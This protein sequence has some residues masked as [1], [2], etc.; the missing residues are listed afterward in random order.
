MQNRG[1]DAEYRPPL[2]PRS[3]RP[4]LAAASYSGEQGFTSFPPPP[5]GP[6]T[7]SRGSSPIPPDGL[8]PD[9]PPPELPPRPAGLGNAAIYGYRPNRLESASSLSPPWNAGRPTLQ[10]FP[11]PPPSPNRPHSSQG[12]KPPP[13]PPRPTPKPVDISSIPPSN[14]PSTATSSP[15]L[16]SVQSSPNLTSFPPPPPGPPP[17]IPSPSPSQSP[18]PGAAQVRTGLS[19]KPS[20][21][22]SS[23]ISLPYSHVQHENG[24][25]VSLGSSAPDS[26]PP[27]Y[28]PS[29]AIEAR[30]SPVPTPPTVVASPAP[31]GETPVSNP[32]SPGELSF[33]PLPPLGT[34]PSPDE[35][36][37]EL[38][39]QMM[40]PAIELTDVDAGPSP[41]QGDDTVR[42]RP[43]SRQSFSGHHSEPESG[44]NPIAPLK[45]PKTP[46]NSRRPASVSFSSAG[47]PWGPPPT[48]AEPASQNG[49]EN[50]SAV[51]DTPSNQAKG[52]SSP[53]QSKSAPLTVAETSTTAHSAPYELYALDYYYPFPS[54]DHGVPPD[55]DGEPENP[56]ASSSVASRPVTTCIDAPVTF[57]TTWYSHFAA[58]E[59]FICSRCYADHIESS[60]FRDSFHVSA[61]AEGEPRV[62][63][64]SS[65]RMKDDLW[66]KAVS[67][68]YLQPVTDWMQ[69]RSRIPDCKGRAGV[70]GSDA[71]AMQWYSPKLHQFPSWFLVCQACYEDRIKVFPQ[72]SSYFEPFTQTQ[73]P[74]DAWSCDFYIP[75]VQKEYE[76]QGPRGDWSTF[77]REARA[78]M[79]MPGCPKQE[80]HFAYGRA[81]FRPVHGP[82]WLFVC[83]SCFSDR[84]AHTDDASKWAPDEQL[85]NMEGGQQVRCPMG[86]F[87]ISMA[88]S[89]AH[90]LQDFSVFWAAVNK[91]GQEKFCDPSGIIDGVWYTLHGVEPDS[92]YQVCSACYVSVAEPLGLSQFFRRKIN[93]PPGATLPCCMNPAHPRA[94]SFIPLL[95]ETYYTMSLAALAAYAD[96][97]AAIPPCPRDSDAR[98]DRGAALHTRL[99]GLMTL[100]N[101]P[102]GTKEDEDEDGINT[103]MCEMYSPRMRDLYLLC[104]GTEQATPDP[105]PLLEFATRRRRVFAETVL[106]IRKMLLVARLALAGQ[107]QQGEQTPNA[108][109]SDPVKISRYQMELI[110]DK[111]GSSCSAY[112][113]S[114]SVLPMR[115]F[116]TLQQLQA[117]A[118]APGVVAELS[119][120]DTLEKWWRSVE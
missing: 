35:D 9:G 57:N 63:R 69:L 33:F 110:R 41:D 2:P 36:I 101:S 28:T 37:N 65:P 51:V 3:P 82:E 79:V 89:R 7:Q 100:R 98:G 30:T 107:Q 81:W 111:M 86:Q 55:E 42:V 47:V 83:E 4:P 50:E 1:Y 94:H 19:P 61:P 59:F 58:P 90:D 116:D 120:V 118:A 64:F 84:V 71:G 95:L 14:I 80:P 70:K 73:P 108:P 113:Y 26:L 44:S 29:P 115:I 56:H 15:L 78:R 74:Q 20:N 53:D 11:P 31:N 114:S 17:P 34:P 54:H 13:L 49:Q 97:Y 40:G 106:P 60:V 8:P 68:E 92:G 77:A 6:P 87:N 48:D 52:H 18:A 102:I 27:P 5:P 119:Q 72:L 99:A 32:Q 76:K 112:M 45:P 93:I 75:F 16:P 85:S 25:T 67:T 24:S 117:Q 22:S 39:E 109:T 43:L 96:V 10:S 104:N 12:S 23:N 21:P 38:L 62:C 66:K 105:K 91:L 88:M 103:P 46:L